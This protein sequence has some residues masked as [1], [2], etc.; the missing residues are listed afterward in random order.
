MKATKILTIALMALPLVISSCGS[1]KKAV[2]A[3]SRRR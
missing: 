1:K 2:V 3:T